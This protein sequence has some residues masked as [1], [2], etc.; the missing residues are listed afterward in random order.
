MATLLGVH[1]G[2]LFGLA[3]HESMFCITIIKLHGV[4]ACSF[5]QPQLIVVQQILQLWVMMMNWN[6]NLNLLR[7]T[8]DSRPMTWT[9][10]PDTSCWVVVLGHQL[11]CHLFTQFFNILIHQ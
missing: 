11:V 6:W 7:L 4:L 5:Y 10:H 8:L 9:F 3:W 2:M 1:S